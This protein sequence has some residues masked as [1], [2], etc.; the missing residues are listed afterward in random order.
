M[1]VMSCHSTCS[2]MLLILAEALLDLDSAGDCNLTDTDTEYYSSS[3][4]EELPKPTQATGFT[5]RVA[6]EVH[7]FCQTFWSYCHSRPFRDPLGQPI[8]QAKQCVNA[9]EMSDVL[10]HL[11]QCCPPLLT[12]ISYSWVTTKRTRASIWTF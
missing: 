12:M 8:L 5:Q 6:V 3:E 10:L 9:R 2:L 11:T 1:H 4:D 7:I